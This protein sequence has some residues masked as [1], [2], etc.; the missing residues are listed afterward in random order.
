MAYFG[1][2]Q[3]LRGDPGFFGTLFGGVKKLAGGIFRSTPI[4]GAIDA[5]VPPRGG[6]IQ[7][8]APPPMRTAQRGGLPVR[9]DP[10]AIL[11]GGRPALFVDPQ[12]GMFRRRRRRMN[13]GNTKALRR[14]I[15]RTDAFVGLAKSA[16]KNTGWKVVSKSSGKMTEAA[17]RK[18]A[19]H[20]K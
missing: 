10:T 9:F 5:F 17:F 8:V 12:T 6:G 13:A 20:A 11:P 15:R 7:Q 4:G 19:H 1:G 14:A 18:R 16:L 3:N 2:S